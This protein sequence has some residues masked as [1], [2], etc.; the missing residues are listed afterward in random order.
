MKPLDTV[1]ANT[2]RSRMASR[3]ENMPTIGNANVARSVGVATNY[4][5]LCVE[6]GHTERYLRRYEE[7]RDA[8]KGGG[9]DADIRAMGDG[10]TVRH[11]RH[12]QLLMT[13]KL[14][15]SDRFRSTTLD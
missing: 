12:P 13:L 15:R 11:H 1:F 7:A 10:V 14:T 4:A 2:Y 9:A 8:R 6:Y 5:T 3:F